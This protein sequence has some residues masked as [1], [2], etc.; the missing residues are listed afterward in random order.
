MV[1]TANASITDTFPQGCEVK[2][3]GFSDNYLIFNDDGRQTL[4]LIQNRHSQ[5]IELKRL[6]TR[7]VLMNPPL[8]AKLHPLQWAAFAS[9]IENL[10]FQCLVKDTDNT[11]N[12][13]IECRKVLDVCK[14]PRVKF[15]LSNMGN[16]WV[17]VDKNKAEVIAE[18]ARKG[19][20]LHW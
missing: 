15:A 10:Y 2:G 14:Y 16:Y 13:T 18:A 11:F 20:Y 8:N 3:F 6:E 12:K 9:D 1:L 7:N 17:V 5:P 19:I 4:Y